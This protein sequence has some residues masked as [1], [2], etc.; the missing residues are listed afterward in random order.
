MHRSPN[1]GLS[2]RGEAA[3]VVELLVAFS[4]LNRHIRNLDIGIISFYNEQVA[5]IKS[6]VK[7]SSLDKWMFSNKISLQ[8]STVDGF[9]GCEKDIIILSCVR[10]KWMNGKFLFTRFFFHKYR[11]SFLILFATR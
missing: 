2:N 6:R 4:F 1:G 7:T 3:F 10:S 11:D 9:Q 5:E 8:I